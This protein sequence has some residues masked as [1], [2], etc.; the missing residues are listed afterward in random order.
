MRTPTILTLVATTGALALAGPALAA[1]VGPA[2]TV[3]KAGQPSPITVAG[4]G[5]KQGATLKAGQRLIARDVTLTGSE[6]RRVTMTCP[7]TSRL[8]G[9]AVDGKVGFAVIQKAN[10]AGQRSVTVRSY[11]DRKLKGAQDGKI[12]ALCAR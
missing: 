12:Y 3:A 4:T 11:T 5:L 7:G 6:R 10:Y 9:L 2:T 1:E 8:R